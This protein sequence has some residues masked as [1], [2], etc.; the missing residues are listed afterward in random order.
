MTA[1]VRITALGL[2]GIL[3]GA[4]L[5]GA[6][7]PH[8]AY[9]LTDDEKARLRVEYDALQ[10]E[11][12]QWQKVLDDTRAKKSSLQGDVTALNAQIAKAT[13]EI[14]QRN[15]TISTLAGEINDKTARISKLQEEIAMGQESL[16]KLLRQKQ[17]GETRSLVVL[18]LS[19]ENLS[20]F[21]GDVSNIDSINRDLRTKFAELRAAK[22]ETE[23]EK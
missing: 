8:S 7:L 21:F 3:I 14:K 22:D 5:F 9:A 13:A 23:V 15:T 6:F 17:E 16:A 20:A 4:G 12:L 11:I 19:S 1:L 2:L 10:Q 18:A